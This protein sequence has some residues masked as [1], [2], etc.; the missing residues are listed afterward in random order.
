[1]EYQENSENQQSN[2]SDVRISKI[3]EI[4]RSQPIQHLTKIIDSAK[5]WIIEDRSSA[6]DALMESLQLRL[7]LHY[8]M[9]ELQR[10]YQLIR[11]GKAKAPNLQITPQTNIMQQEMMN[12]AQQAQF[13]APQYQQFQNSQQ[14]QMG[15]MQQQMYMQQQQFYSQQPFQQQVMPQMDLQQ[16]ALIQQLLSIS[17][18]QL[19]MLPPDQQQQILEIRAQYLQSQPNM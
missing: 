5:K 16:L 7:A 18:E 2:I 14:F 6:K 8:V 19:A 13:Q 11:E 12:S 3:E 1:M 4:V 15:N 17:N 9:N 10:Q